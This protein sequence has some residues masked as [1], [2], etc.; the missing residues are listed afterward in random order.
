MPLL[1]WD[2][3]VRSVIWKQDVALQ[4]DVAISAKFFACLHSPSNAR[5]TALVMRKLCT[6]RPE[7]QPCTLWFDEQALS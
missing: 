2:D 4:S 5:I 6:M 3:P 7:K 1:R